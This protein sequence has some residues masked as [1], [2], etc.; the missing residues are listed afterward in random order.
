MAARRALHSSPDLPITAPEPAIKMQTRKP[1]PKASPKHYMPVAAPKPAIK[2]QTR[3][4]TPTA[5]PKTVTKSLPTAASCVAKGKVE[6]QTPACVRTRREPVR[7]CRIVDLSQPYNTNS[8]EGA[9]LFALRIFSDA[10]ATWERLQQAG[11]SDFELQTAIES[12]FPVLLGFHAQRQKGFYIGRL[13]EPFFL[14]GNPEGTGGYLAGPALLK[15][16]RD[17]LC[18][19][20]SKRSK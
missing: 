17:V 1:A 10:S 7:S 9:L 2:M 18:L 20:D 16:V 15:K 14:W 11:A 12:Y 3:K 6:S 19:P 5:L 8:R 4:P 13:P